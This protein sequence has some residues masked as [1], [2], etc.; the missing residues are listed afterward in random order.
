MALFQQSIYW[1]TGWGKLW[2]AAFAFLTI[3]YLA[4]FIT[5]RAAKGGN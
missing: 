2:V 3:C 5:S 4:G 1:R